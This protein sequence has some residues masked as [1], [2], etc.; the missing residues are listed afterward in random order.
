MIK[1]NYIVIP[2]IA[3]LISFSGSFL[4]R[5]GMQWYRTLTLPSLTPPGWVFGAVWTIIYVLTSLAAIYVWNTYPRN[6][7]F[8]AIMALFIINAVANLAW[9][10]IFFNQH[11]IALA[12]VDSIVLW[13][14]ALGLI[15]LT[16][17]VAWV[18]ALLLMPYLAWLTFATYLGWRIMQLN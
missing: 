5:N 6:N 12:L 17:Q 1:L 9:S 3:A 18:P 13:V 4:S 11:L 8:F 7:L 2:G 15:V 10:Y 16:A 14:T